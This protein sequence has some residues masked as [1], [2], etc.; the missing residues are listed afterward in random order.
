M[1][2]AFYGQKC[3]RFLAVFGLKLAVYGQKLA[4]VVY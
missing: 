2:L 4:V 3:K 1:I